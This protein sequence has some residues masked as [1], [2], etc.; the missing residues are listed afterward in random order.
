MN[1]YTTADKFLQTYILPRMNHKNTENLNRPITS[2]DIESVI[3]N[4]PTNKCP[5]PDDFTGEFTH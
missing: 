2:K 4:L 1:N 5:R 3:K